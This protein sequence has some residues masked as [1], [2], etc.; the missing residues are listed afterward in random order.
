MGRVYLGEDRE[1]QRRVALKLLH[2]EDRIQRARFRAE[3]RA[4]AALSHP[5]IVTVFEIGD[6]DGQRFIA[7]EFLEGS[8]LRDLLTDPDRRPGRERLLAIHAQVAA[9]VA[10][11]HEAGILHRDIKPE[12]VIVSPA[13]MVKVVDFGIARRLDGDESTAETGPHGVLTLPASAIAETMRFGSSAVATQPTVLPTGPTR[14]VFGTPAYMAPEVLMGEPSSPASD[15]YSLGVMLYECLAGRRPYEGTAH[16]VIAKVVDGSEPPP[17]LADRHAALISRMLD[18]EPAMRPT[19]REIERALTIRPS[20]VRS[21]AVLL[22]AASVLALAIG[23]VAMSRMAGNEPAAPT[24]RVTIGVDLLPARLTTFAD[25]QPHAQ[26]IGDIF[27]SELAS[28]TPVRAISP[29]VTRGVALTDEVPPRPDCDWYIRGTI[30]QP[31]RGGLIAKLELIDTRTERVFPLVGTAPPDQLVPLVVELAGRVIGVVQPTS[32]PPVRDRMRAT[33]IYLQ[34]LSDFAINRWV[35]A[36]V[37]LEHAVLVDPTLPQA[38]QALAAARGWS[39]ASQERTLE[40]I[41]RTIELAPE[42]PQRAL[43][44]GAQQFYRYEFATAAAMLAPLVDQP[45]L[46]A[47][48]RDSLLYYLGEAYYH[49]GQHRLGVQHLA[50]V[51]ERRPDFRPPVIHVIDDAIVHRDYATANR[52]KGL[53]GTEIRLDFA[54]QRYRELIERNVPG[55]SLWAYLVLEE[56]PPAEIV[57]KLDANNAAFWR[58]AEAD[59]E[60]ARRAFETQWDRLSRLAP[61]AA[62]EDLGR[63]FEIA[64]AKGRAADV[65]RI[66]EHVRRHAAQFRGHHKIELLAAPLLGVPPPPLDKLTTREQH[67]AR[68]TEAELAGDH[69]RAVALLRALLAEPGVHWDYPERAALLRNLR[70]LRARKEVAQICRELRHPP[71]FRYAWLPLRASCR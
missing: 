28:Y 10:V 3:A 41:T 70:A 40:A 67:L 57:T 11:A 66:V 71:V 14:S 25:D 53:D 20:P 58:Y 29:R 42:G 33:E 2:H 38:W 49:D 22:I 37:Y 34:A 4:L 24:Q 60:A 26:A 55:W 32:E 9:A 69:R 45:E 62:Q 5:N 36:R 43:W 18:P 1:L 15:V 30:E 46:S 17:P 47:I 12:N 59:E 35:I 54:R 31:D 16:E 51:A 65:R 44:L 27:A 61:N 64:L 52:Y 56:E 68:A 7:M 19:L 13:G 63:L 50:E 48:D 39:L 8:T 21:R 6:H 23:G